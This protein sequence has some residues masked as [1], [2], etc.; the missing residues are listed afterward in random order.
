MEHDKYPVSYDSSSCVIIESAIVSK[1][2]FPSSVWSFLENSYKLPARGA[3]FNHVIFVNTFLWNPENPRDLLFG[4]QGRRKFIIGNVAVHV[5]TLHLHHRHVLHI[6]GLKS[7]CLVRPFLSRK[8]DRSEMFNISYMT[9]RTRSASL[10]QRTTRRTDASLH[11][12]L[13]GTFI[14]FS[15]CW[16]TSC[17]W[18]MSTDASHLWHFKLAVKRKKKKN[19]VSHTKFSA[20]PSLS[21]PL[22]PDTTIEY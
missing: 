20:S 13:Q 22:C 14:T 5:N 11:S 8:L 9:N 16:P 10:W 7:I 19:S 6:Y 18:G 17:F 21:P 1:G 2:L 4:L 3:T 12:S 15:A